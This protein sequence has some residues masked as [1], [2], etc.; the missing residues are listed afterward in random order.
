VTPAVR[1]DPETIA[2]LRGLE[3]RARHVV[4]G[5]LAGRQRSRRRGQSIEFAEHREYAPGDDQRYVDWKA[6]AKTDR[7]YVKQF[8]AETDLIVYLLVDSSESMQ[9]RG[10]GAVLSKWE[11]AQAL[12]GALAYLAVDQRDSVALLTYADCVRR[13]LPPGSTPSQFRQAIAILEGE[14]PEGRTDPERAFADA[15]RRA[16]RRGLVIVI[17]DLL[18]DVAPLLQG[19]RRLRR[20]QHE[21][22][23]LQVL[24]PAEIEFPF[25]ESLQ[26]RGL[27]ARPAVVADAGGLRRAYRKV[28]AEYLTALRGGCRERQIDHELARTDERLDAPLRRLLL[29][30]GAR[31]AFPSS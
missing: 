8:E 7:L 30:R 24:D 16:A 1:P 28:F 18:G 20:A 9:Y 11:Y 29:N 12:A 4:D 17:S 27:E 2:R 14:V 21:V 15:A 3:L 31:P 26:F 5:F 10:P 25:A 6:F 23:V 22:A 19:L 13:A